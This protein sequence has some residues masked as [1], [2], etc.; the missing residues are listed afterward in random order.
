MKPLPLAI[1]LFLAS[2]A[3]AAD[4]SKLAPAAKAMDM[5]GDVSVMAH[6]GDERCAVVLF[7]DK[8]SEGYRLEVADGCASAFPVMGKA[9]AWRV[10]TDRIVAFVDADGRDLIRFKGKGYTRYAVKNVD[11]IDRI[12]SAQDVAE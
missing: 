2:P 7:E 1:L 5:M 8:V 9:K 10:Y 12:Y 6:E 3:L 4:S 11:G